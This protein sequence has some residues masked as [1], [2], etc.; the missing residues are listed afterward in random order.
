MVWNVGDRLAIVAEKIRNRRICMG[1]Y[2]VKAVGSKIGVKNE[3]R[4]G[5]DE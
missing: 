1:G 3:D 5:E 4:G 2:P